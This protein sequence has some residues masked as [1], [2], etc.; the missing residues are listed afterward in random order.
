VCKSVSDLR[1]SRTEFDQHCHPK[2]TLRLQPLNLM[3]TVRKELFGRF[4]ERIGE[5]QWT[6]FWQSEVQNIIDF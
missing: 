1:G 5:R 6:A 4:I 2:Q 3:S